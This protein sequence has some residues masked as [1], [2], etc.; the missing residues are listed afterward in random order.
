MTNRPTDEE[1]TELHLLCQAAN[2]GGDCEVRRL[3]FAA[4]EWLPRL[5]PRIAELE[6]ERDYLRKTHDNADIRIA[7]LTRRLN[8]LHELEAERDKLQEA[9]A[10]AVWDRETLRKYADRI[11]ELEAEVAR[12]EAECRAWEAQ[13]WEA[14]EEFTADLEDSTLSVGEAYAYRS[15]PPFPKKKANS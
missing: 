10:N 3:G 6:A 13:Y 15:L 12:L 7:Q 5:L 4:R 8:E 11:A 14:Q 9:V 2:S 1:T